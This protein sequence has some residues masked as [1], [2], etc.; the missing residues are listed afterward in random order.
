MPASGGSPSTSIA[1]W[2]SLNEIEISDTRFGIDN[3]KERKEAFEVRIMYVGIW[4]SMDTPN[5]VEQKKSVIK[6]ETGR[7]E[8]ARDLRA[9]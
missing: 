3:I 9:L 5:T 7:A 4:S 1:N 2:E 8:S 6:A